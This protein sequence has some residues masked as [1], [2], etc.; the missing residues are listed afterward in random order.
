M[1]VVEEVSKLIVGRRKEIFLLLASLVS[2]GHVLIE[3]VPGVAKTLLA[4]AFAYTLSLEYKR[5][6]F[7]PDILP[8]DIT[9][10]YVFDQRSGEFVF[11]KGP[12]F[13]N[14]L[15]A[16]EINRAS[17][18]T[19]SALLEAMQ[20]QQ[21]TIEGVTYSLP[22]PFMVIATL[23]PIETEGVFPLPE[24]QLDRF[25]LKISLGYPSPKEESEILHRQ[26]SIR[27][28]IIGR[29]ACRDDVLRLQEMFWDVHVSDVVERYIVDVVVS[30]RR[31]KLVRLGA[32]PRATVHLYLI[33]K[34]YA[35]LNGRDY[36]LPDDVK[37]LVLPVLS[38][39]IILNPDALYNGIRGEDVIKDVLK[40]IIIPA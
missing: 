19:Q 4:K 14:I 27:K 8:S 1:R 13:T 32:S 28:W 3:G 24:A 9:G 11:R 31:H 18:K 39:R 33:S 21:V 6:Q 10:T 36:V 23:N 7:T 5:I 20:E 34:A 12:I 22:K 25:S 29:V 2:G 40:K 30:T 15:L 17:P 37:N 38:H 16:D 26:L 35:L